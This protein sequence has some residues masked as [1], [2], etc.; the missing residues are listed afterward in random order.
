MA[1][2]PIRMHIYAGSID[3]ILFQEDAY[4]QKRQIYFGD[5]QQFQLPF[6]RRTNFFAFQRREKVGK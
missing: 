5:Y 4:D 2:I 6:D 1:A 3:G